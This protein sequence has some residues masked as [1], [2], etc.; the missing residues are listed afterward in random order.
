MAQDHGLCRK[1]KQSNGPGARAASAGPC[2]SCQQDS[3]AACKHVG[4]ELDV[5]ILAHMDMNRA[6]QS[7]MTGRT[8]QM[9]RAV[10]MAGKEWQQAH[11]PQNRHCRLCF[12]CRAIFACHVHCPSLVLAPVQF[13]FVCFAPVHSM[14]TRIIFPEYQHVCK[15]RDCPVGSC[16]TGLQWWPVR[17][18]HLTASFSCRVHDPGPWVSVRL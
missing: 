2:C 1:K 3:L 6:K 8:G 10:G 15:L 16:N 5:P 11:S 12:A 9:M 7:K 14:C 4:F 17:R 18:V 13:A